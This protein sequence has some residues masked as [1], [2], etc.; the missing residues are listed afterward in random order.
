MLSTHGATI[1]DRASFK[2]GSWNNKKNILITT[3]EQ[4]IF[5]IVSC[6]PRKGEYLGHINTI[7]T[8]ANYLRENSR[9]KGHRE[10]KKS[11]FENLLLRT[12]DNG[13]TFENSFQVK[14]W[15]HK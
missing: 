8:I 2:P 12:F 6:P 15:P 9:K 1:P 10:K 14:K 5:D 4:V 13:D 7:D 11:G 3:K